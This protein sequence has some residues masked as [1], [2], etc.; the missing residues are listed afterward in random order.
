M[1][2]VDKFWRCYVVTAVKVLH[3]FTHSIYRNSYTLPLL[4]LCEFDLIGIV[5]QLL[6]SI[7]SRPLRV[8][9]FKLN[10]VKQKENQKKITFKNSENGLISQTHFTLQ[11]TLTS[12]GFIRKIPNVHIL[13]IFQLFQ[14]RRQQSGHCTKTKRVFF[15]LITSR[16]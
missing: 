7:N 12:N 3:Y 14:N 15:N 1:I 10:T 4:C 6:Y 16:I 8:Y 13:I 2:D 5:F 11:W 9:W